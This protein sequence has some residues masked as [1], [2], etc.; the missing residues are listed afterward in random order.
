MA[1]GNYRITALSPGFVERVRTTRTDEFGN[2]LRP[3]RDRERHQC[4]SCLSLTRP[5]E[6]YLALSYRPFEKP[7][8]FAESGPIYI[9]ARR[10]E[11]YR[12]ATRYP[13]E[14]PR[15]DVVLRAYT[16]SD[17]IGDAKFVGRR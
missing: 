6:A 9:H 1:E 8:P 14:F 16:S 15:E 7:Q 4:R 10:C 12:E 2:R 5:A 13:E 3:R 17:E 11:P